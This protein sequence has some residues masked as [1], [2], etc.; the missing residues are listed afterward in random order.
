MNDRTSVIREL[1]QRAQ[2]LAA[3]VFVTERSEFT[4]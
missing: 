4:K 2:R 3:R 1:G